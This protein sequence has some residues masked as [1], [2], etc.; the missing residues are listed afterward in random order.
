VVLH[1][2][3]AGI[4]TFV[5]SDS[6]PVGKLP[7]DKCSQTDTTA[8][9]SLAV[10]PADPRHLVAAYPEG[11]FANFGERGAQALGFAVSFDGGATWTHGELPGF[12]TVTGGNHAVAQGE[13]RQR[14]HG[15]RCH[16][17]NY[18]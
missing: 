2:V 5:G 4:D 11:S 18:L 1:D 7:T 15:L 14:R 9:P 12:K 13:H 17:T 10:D 8:E 3:Q 16:P 6:C